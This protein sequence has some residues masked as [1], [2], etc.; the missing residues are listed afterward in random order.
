MYLASLSFL[1]PP[2]LLIISFAFSFSSLLFHSVSSYYL[3]SLRMLL[4]LSPEVHPWLL[5]PLFPS[6]FPTSF[7]FS[8]D[9]SSFICHS[10]PFISSYFLLSLVPLPFLRF[11]LPPLLGCSSFVSFLF[12]ICLFSSRLLLFS[13]YFTFITFSS[14]FSFYHFLRVVHSHLPSLL[15]I[16]RQSISACL[17]FCSYIFTFYLPS[18]PTTY[19]F[20]LFSCTT[21]FFQNLPLIISSLL[22]PLFNPCYLVFFMF[23]F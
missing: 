20:I 6:C 15:P 10:F 5:F 11:L 19:Y 4:F 18:F 7:P 21:S 16:I 23:K 14:S 2:T 12:F 1:P 8:S 17:C 22:L 13:T 9:F 3:P